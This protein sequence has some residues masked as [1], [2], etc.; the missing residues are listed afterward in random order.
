M[1]SIGDV[2]GWGCNRAALC[3]REE[4]QEA[5][6][7]AAVVRTDSAVLLALASL[8]R[9]SWRRL[10]CRRLCGG[11]GCDGGGRDGLSAALQQREE[12]QEANAVAAAVRSDSDVLLALVSLHRRS[13]RRLFCRRLC[14]RRGDCDVGGWA[15]GVVAAAG[16][17]AGSNTVAA[18]VP[19]SAYRAQARKKTCPRRQEQ[20][21]WQQQLASKTT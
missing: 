1:Q 11:G 9:G 8:H 6:A 17:A 12:Q 14:G 18:G 5:N 10:F 20:R 4:Q 7:V 21:Q 13:W 3:Q 15:V 2:E 19:G 16:G